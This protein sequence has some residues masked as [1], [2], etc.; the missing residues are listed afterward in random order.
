MVRCPFYK[1]LLLV[2]SLWGSLILLQTTVAHAETSTIPSD[3][4]FI[5]QFSTATEATNGNFSIQSVPEAQERLQIPAG[6]QSYT[7]FTPDLKPQF[8]SNAF[9][10]KMTGAEITEDNIVLTAH[11]KTKKRSFPVKMSLIGDDIKSP[12][13]QGI[14][15]SKPVTITDLDSFSIEITLDRDAEGNI[16]Q[17]DSLEIIYFNTTEQPKTQSLFK[18]QTAE[19]IAPTTT[20]ST[21]SKRLTVVSRENWGA[22]ES[23][24]LDANNEPLWAENYADPKVFVVHH[25]AAGDGGSD[26]AATIRAIYYW[27]AVVLGWGDIGYNYLIDPS[28]NIY[29][30]RFG[31]DGVVGGHTYNST[32]GIGYNTGSVGIALLGC[33]EYSEGAC[34]TPNTTTPEMKAALVRLLGVKAAKFKINPTSEVA[35]NDV[36]VRRVVAHRDLDYTYCPGNHVYEQIASIRSSA[37]KQQLAITTPAWKGKL[38]SAV[39]ESIPVTEATLLAGKTHEIIVTYKN[40]GTRKW[41]KDETLLKIYNHTGR[42]PSK[43]RHSTWAA[44][45]GNLKMDQDIVAPGETATFRVTIA[46]PNEPKTDNMVIKLVTHKRT[47]AKTKSALTMQFEQKIASQ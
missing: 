8:A 19:T 37:R 33:Y 35:F 17:I 26:P 14:Y 40:T 44:A 3:R 39:V 45:W 5:S 6:E 28:G 43:L 2:V 21:S 10:L 27:H 23:F 41:K 22:D 31:G 15:A 42:R 38:T 47:F 34:A 16:P 13:A 1:K 7:Y 25:T 46:A 9:G 4:F 20:S 24:R 12:L 30:G 36:T 32:K 11:A 18:I 29:H